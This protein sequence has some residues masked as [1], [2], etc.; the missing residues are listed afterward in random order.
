[1]I[2]SVTREQIAKLDELMVD[3]F[4]IPVVMMME[5]ASYRLAEFIRQRYPEQRRVLLCCG[6]GNNGGD[7]IAAARHLLNFGYEP[8]IFLVSEELKADPATHV[9]IAKGLDIRILTRFDDLELLLHDVDLVVDCLLGY[10]LEGGP[11]DAFAEA[12]H[13]INESGKP[14]VACDIPS[15]VDTDEGPIYEPYVRAETILFLS[16]PKRGCDQ[17]EGEKYVADM[18]VPAQLYPMIGLQEKNHFAKESIVKQ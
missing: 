8:V 5:L 17:L 7:G 2:P 11:R 4:K 10:N 12:I 15:G 14:V 13:T 9:E 3:Y 6:K 18:G 1:M 16:L